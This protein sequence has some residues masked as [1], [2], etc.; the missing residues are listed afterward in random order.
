MSLGEF[1]MV[2]LFALARLG[3]GAYG[4]AIWREI[5]DR[6]GREVSVGALY[7]TLDRLEEKGLVRSSVGEPTS[8]RG[9]RRK[10]LF[11]IKAAGR[12]ELEA[13]WDTLAKMRRG[14]SLPAG[15]RS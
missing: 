11:E 3:E 5:R 14:V 4:M 7:T 6:T 10:R 12:V 2:V 15:A 8:R 9:G 1:E 13:S